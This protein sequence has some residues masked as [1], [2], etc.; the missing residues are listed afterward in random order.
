MGV[1]MNCAELVEAVEGQ[2]LWGTAEQIFTGITTDSR[3]VAKDNLFIPLVGE[4]F[5]GHD[6]IPQCVNSGAAVILTEKPISQ[7]SNCTAVLVKDTAKALRDIAAW[8]RNKFDVPV[9]TY[10]GI[11]QHHERYDGTGYPNQTTGEQIS[12]FGR[13]ISIAD[14]YDALTSR[15][16]Y[17]NALTPAVAIEYIMGGSGTLFDPS[18]TSQFLKRVSPYPIGTCVTLSNN[19]TGIVTENHID[20]CLRPKV[21]IFIH[22][23]EKVNPYYID[24]RNDRDVLD[25]VITGIADN[26]GI[27]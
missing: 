6:Y 21:K 17:R 4:R 10:I 5:D 22:G 14:V 24:M 27:I 13:I 11:L 23:S 9:V 18:L 16:P 20:C 3:K 26:A 12:L 19:K 1:Q 7:M 25:V 2:L 8:H 15:R